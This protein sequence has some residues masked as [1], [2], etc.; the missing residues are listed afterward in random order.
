MINCLKV[1]DFAK[2]L[3]QRRAGRETKAEHAFA[4][5]AAI[6]LKHS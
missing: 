2:D 6:S 3:P 4:S 1:C 5:Q